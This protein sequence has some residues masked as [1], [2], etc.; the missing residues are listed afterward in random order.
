MKRNGRARILEIVV[1][2]E[3]PG[4]AGEIWPE[5]MIVQE[6]FGLSSHDATVSY[7]AI[8]ASHVLQLVEGPKVVSTVKCWAGWLRDGGEVHVVVPDLGWACEQVTRQGEVDRY[9]LGVIYGQ[10]YAH[11]CGFTVGM[12]RGVLAATGLKAKAARLGPYAIVGGDG[13]E[14]IAR[15]IYV[16]GVKT[17]GRETA[18]DEEAGDAEEC[19]S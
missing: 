14:V 8:L 2:A 1:S 17:T 4:M 7:D 13:L 5:A 11:R 16:V 19:E 12:L 9:T 3:G 18:T 10:Q 15:Q 6:E